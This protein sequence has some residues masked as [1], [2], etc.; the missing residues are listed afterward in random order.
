MTD[1]YDISFSRVFGNQVTQD[2]STVEGHRK[3]VADA[4]N[5]NEFGSA[6]AS[7]WVSTK[8]DKGV[9]AAS[10]EGVNYYSESYKGGGWKN[11]VSTAMKNYEELL[12]ST[13]DIIAVSLSFDVVNDDLLQFR[14]IY[15]W[16]PTEIYAG[17]CTSQSWEW[18]WLETHSETAAAIQQLIFNTKE[19]PSGAQPE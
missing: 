2:A 7:V 15:T 18:A 13:R 19:E 5:I 3:T 17:Y 1:T 16:T 12:G 14:V 10:V 4:V 11:I 8:D 6:D 9:I